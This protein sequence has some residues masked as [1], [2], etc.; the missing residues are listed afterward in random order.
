MEKEIRY[1]KELRTIK[2]CIERYPN[3]PKYKVSAYT[4]ISLEVI[5][6][7]I[8]QGFLREENGELK[9]AMKSN[10]NNEQRRNLI[11]RLAVD[12]PIHNVKPQER[13]Q[14]VIDLIN[15]KSREMSSEDWER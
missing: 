11:N 4:G 13:S 15:K 6:E 12:T 8:D 5:R 7:L 10:I 3:E 1:K 9:V 14:L 2:D